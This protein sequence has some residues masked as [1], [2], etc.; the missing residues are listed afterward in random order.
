MGWVEFVLQSEF[1][2]LLVVSW[3]MALSTQHLFELHF[4]LE[5]FV[6]INFIILQLV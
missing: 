6:V 3:K 2:I 4:L 1:V 5:I